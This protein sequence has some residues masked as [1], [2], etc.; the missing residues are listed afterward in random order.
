MLA[1]WWLA[2]RCCCSFDGSAVANSSSKLCCP[3]HSAPR[4]RYIILSSLCTY[5]RAARLPCNAPARH[6]CAMM[7]QQRPLCVCMLH[8]MLLQ[9][10]E[11]A[12]ALVTLTESLLRACN[13]LRLCRGRPLKQAIQECELRWFH[14][15]AALAKEGEANQMALLGTYSATLQPL[16]QHQHHVAWQ[17]VHNICT[18]DSWQQL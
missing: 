15:T 13:C 1:W 4:K 10:H 16:Q 11:V 3:S 5:M 14:E 12:P 2:C 8:A 7:C 17:L 6:Q 18:A 9:Q